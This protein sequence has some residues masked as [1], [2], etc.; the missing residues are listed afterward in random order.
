MTCKKGNYTKANFQTDI[1]RKQAMFNR[2]KRRFKTCKNPTEK[3]FLKTEA[4]RVVGEL[5]QCCKR[6][7]TWGFGGYTWIIKNYTVTSFTAGVR[8]TAYKSTTGRTYA[9]KTTR[10]SAKWPKSRTHVRSATRK[11]YSAW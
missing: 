9:H 7:Q 6:W 2:F 10:T 8:P 11:N 3:R 5:K 4:T 1:K